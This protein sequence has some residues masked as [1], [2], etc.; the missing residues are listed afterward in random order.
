MA[1]KISIKILILFTIIISCKNRSSKSE[2]NEALIQQYF[3]YFNKHNWKS[4]ADMYIETAEFKDP[5][6]GT[7]IVKQTKQE[8]LNKY[9][10]LNKVFPDLHDEIINIYP[11]GENNV[12]VEFKSSGTGPDNEK[13]ELPICTIF[14]INNGLIS[15][16]FTYFDNFEE[17]KIEK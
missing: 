7:G 14:T 15:K 8:T 16:D 5:T 9:S 6:L 12:I 1:M 4:M 2:N 13:F 11:S 3:E 10:E 17:Q